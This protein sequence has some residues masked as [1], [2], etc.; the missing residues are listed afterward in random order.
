V[1]E[2]DLPQGWDW[3]EPDAARIEPPAELCR[4][5]AACF[6]GPSG[7]LVLRHLQRLFADRRLPPSATDAELRHVEGQ[8][9]V[10]SH[11]LRLLER[12]RGAV[13]AA[14]STLPGPKD[15]R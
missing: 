10:V 3:L 2:A 9:S 1:S 12:G 14:D 6:G 8:R 15:L 11:L 5:A 4:C 7:R 13:T